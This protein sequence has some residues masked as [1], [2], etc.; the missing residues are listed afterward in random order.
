MGK[1]V[2]NLAKTQ[3]L[4][5]QDWF[6]DSGTMNHMTTDLNKFDIHSEYKGPEEVTLGNGSKLPISHID[7]SSITSSAKKFKLDDFLHVPTATPNL[8]SV[9][10]FAKSNNVSVEFFPNHFSIKDLATRAPLHTQR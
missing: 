9:N 4:P 6:M 7:K 10:S 5:T 1:P 8:V 3:P 2:S